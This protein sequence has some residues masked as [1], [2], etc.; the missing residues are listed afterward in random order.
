MESNYSN[1][2]YYCPYNQENYHPNPRSQ[3]PQQTKYLDNFLGDYAFDD[4]NNDYQFQDDNQNYREF[5]QN[6]E[7]EPQNYDE[8]KVL[9]TYC[10]QSYPL[11]S[12]AEHDEQCDMKKI[13]CEKCGKKVLIE[14]FDQH[15]LECSSTGEQRGNQRQ[16]NYDY[17]NPRVD[18]GL[19]RRQY[20]TGL[21]YNLRNRNQPG[22][23][24]QTR[25]PNIAPRRSYANRLPLYEPNNYIGQYQYDLMDHQLDSEIPESATYE[26][27]LALDNNIIKKGLTKTQLEKFRIRTFI[28]STES[29][30]PC[31]ICMSDFE[32]GERLRKI[33]CGHEFHVSCID[34]WLKENITC[35][36]C[37]KE[38][39]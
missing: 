29:T 19:N 20:G 39:R 21:T 25:I 28:T 4:D 5:E 6:K 35:P 9:C 7:A 3:L 31:S 32:M 11:H 22:R 33:K 13:S 12:F 8:V 30:Q 23:G 10:N 16:N 17:I 34:T 38:L 26:D 27:L 36:V 15:E 24:N 1:Y 2:H 37:K 14:V 18:T